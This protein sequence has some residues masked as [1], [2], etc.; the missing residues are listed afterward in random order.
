MTI[1]DLSFDDYNPY[2]QPYIDKVGDED[3]LNTMKTN[4]KTVPSFLKSINS[5]RLDFRYAECKWTIKEILLH[6]IDTER[7][8]AYRALCIARHDKTEFPGFD[9]DNYVAYSDANTRTLESLLS[10]FDSV[11]RATL[12][13]FES[14]DDSALAQIGVASESKLSVIAIPFIIV[15]HENHH[16]QIIKERYL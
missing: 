12:M 1:N 6:L 11:R 2:Y 16:L 15:G 5:D 14:F 3:I 10:E 13:L 9:Q 4:R 8:F 7:V